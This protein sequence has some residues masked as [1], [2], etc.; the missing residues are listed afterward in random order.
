[1]AREE[2]SMVRKN[3]RTTGHCCVEIGIPGSCYQY[4][5]QRYNSAGSD[6]NVHFPF[7]SFPPSDM[8][9]LVQYHY[10]CH[11]KGISP[12]V[13]HEMQNQ[14]QSRFLY[15]SVGSRKLRWLSFSSTTL[16]P[17]MARIAI[18]VSIMN[19]TKTG[20]SPSPLIFYQENLEVSLCLF[21]VIRF[22]FQRNTSRECQTVLQLGS[23]S[24]KHAL[25]Y[26]LQ[27]LR[28]SLSPQ[29]LIHAE[30]RLLTWKRW[31]EKPNKE[32]EQVFQISLWLS[33]EILS[34]YRSII[35]CKGL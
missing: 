34:C 15:R 31:V 7:C 28:V 32:I 10:L 6:V 2:Q 4:Q 1:M 29:P 20:T 8:T 30:H 17:Y 18:F 19:L 22:T 12:V 24:R 33:M 14:R 27:W 5:M 13:H 23:L 9:D 26:H 35:L 21:S 3:S 16:F 25:I 11:T